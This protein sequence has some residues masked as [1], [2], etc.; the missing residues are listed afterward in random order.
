ML[1]ATHRLG[2]I[3]QAHLFRESVRKTNG[4]IADLAGKLDWDNP[5][6]VFR[7]MRKTLHL[8]RDRLPLNEAV[9]L[10]AEFPLVLRGAYFEGWKPSKNPDKTLGE[11]EFL[12]ALNREF[13]DLENFDAEQVCRCVFGVLRSRITEGEARDVRGALPGGLRSLWDRA[14]DQTSAAGSK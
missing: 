14:T 7:A 10:A 3:E 11:K 12:E 1:Q 8:L 4:W 5:S 13:R 6:Q 2:P 9:Q